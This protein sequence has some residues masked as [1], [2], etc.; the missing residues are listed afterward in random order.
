MDDAL[1]PQESLTVIAF[2]S[3]YVTRGGAGGVQQSERRNPIPVK[4]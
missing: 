3:F 4:E 2:T 1:E